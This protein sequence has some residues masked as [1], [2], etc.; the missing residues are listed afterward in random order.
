M[1]ADGGGYVIK[2]D[3]DKYDDDNCDD[4]GG[5]MSC[6]VSIINLRISY[7][8][9]QLGEGDLYN[10]VPCLENC[11]AKSSLERLKVIFFQFF[12]IVSELIVGFINFYSSHR[13]ITVCW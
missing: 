13:P 7:F 4:C 11:L 1:K 12:A 8:H 6:N 10:T 9:F 2:D 3:C 5:N